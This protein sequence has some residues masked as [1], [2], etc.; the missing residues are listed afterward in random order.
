MKRV[1]KKAN[2][3]QSAVEIVT[4]GIVIALDLNCIRYQVPIAQSRSI[5]VLQT[6]PYEVRTGIRLQTAVTHRDV[7]NLNDV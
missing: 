3:L 4:Q 7:L 5:S 1:S 6:H 2:T